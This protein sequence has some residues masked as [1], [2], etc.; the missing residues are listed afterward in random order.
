MRSDLTLV[1][2]HKDG[3]TLLWDISGDNARPLLSVS[4]RGRHAVRCLGMAEQLG[5]LVV[6]HTNGKV[7]EGGAHAGVGAG[8]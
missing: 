6:G 2:G 1:T 4:P 3:S 7:R 8:V 5:L